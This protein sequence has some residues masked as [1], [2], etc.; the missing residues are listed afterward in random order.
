MQGNISLDI[1]MKSVLHEYKLY[2]SIPRKLNVRDNCNDFRLRSC[3][4]SIFSLYMKHSI[5][6]HFEPKMSYF[7]EEFLLEV[8]LVLIG[9][10]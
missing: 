5:Q 4:L 2:Y 7:L 9:Y 6:H 8:P 3:I 1:Y 10:R